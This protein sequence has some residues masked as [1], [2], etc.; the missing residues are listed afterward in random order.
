M[1]EEQN[2]SKLVVEF[3]KIKVQENLVRKMSKSG[4]RDFLRLFM[5]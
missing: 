5:R 1:I 3:S 2:E 4:T